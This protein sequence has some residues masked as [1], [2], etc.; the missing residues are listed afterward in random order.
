MRP[1]PHATWPHPHAGFTLV[2]V[3]IALAIISVAL[4]AFVRTTSQTT[5]NLGALE[6]RSLAMLSAENAIAL[7]RISLPSQPGVQIID[8]P[9]ADQAFVCRVQVG[10]V[11]QGLRG[12]VAEV[13]PNRNSSER[14]A[15]V[16][17]QLPEQP[18]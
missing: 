9:Q 10:P 12:I 3:L 6:R 4:A 5:T 14:L 2:E 8:C 15:S 13:Y 18:K 16:Q 17:T 7:M 11:Q 1:S